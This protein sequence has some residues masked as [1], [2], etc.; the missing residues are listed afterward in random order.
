VKVSHEGR[1]F[2]SEHLK[3]DTRDDAGG[4]AEC[5]V[6]CGTR[7]GDPSHGDENDGEGGKPET[8]TDSEHPNGI[9]G[10]VQEVGDVEVTEGVLVG[11]PHDVRRHKDGPYEDEA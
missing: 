3:L 8:P 10:R 5:E 7:I 9:L 6:P 1:S 2:Q 4:P 11:I